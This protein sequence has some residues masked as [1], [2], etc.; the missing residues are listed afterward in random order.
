L[1]LPAS[2]NTRATK[3]YSRLTLGQCKDYDIVKREILSSFRLTGKAYLERFHAATRFS[4]EDHRL[5]L[6]RLQELQSYDM[7]SKQLDTFEKL[8]DDVLLQQFLSSL[9]PS[10]R[11]FV[12]CRMPSTDAQAAEFADLCVE[13][14][15]G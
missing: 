8:R 3:V 10:V 5:F 4:D 7:E 14:S 9:Q 6:N 2:L 1:Y 12:E 11:H 15:L 13:T